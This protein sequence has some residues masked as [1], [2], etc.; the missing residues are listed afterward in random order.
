MDLHFLLGLKAKASH[1]R[2]DNHAL[3]GYQAENSPHLTVRWEISTIT[4]LSDLLLVSYVLKYLHGYN[5]S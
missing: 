3:G 5:T 4:L 2:G 1:L